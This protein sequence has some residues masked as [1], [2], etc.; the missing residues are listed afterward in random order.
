[1][2][3]YG[4]LTTGSFFHLS[5]PH[6]YFS[7][8]TVII[9]IPDNINAFIHLLN[10]VLYKKQFLDQCITVITNKILQAQVQ[11]TFVILFCP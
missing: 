9:L 3:L 1:M 5:N 8:P 4:Y 10:P 2:T 6:L 11:D 7:S